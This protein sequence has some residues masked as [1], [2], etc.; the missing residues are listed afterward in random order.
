MFT[1]IFDWLMYFA[2]LMVIMVVVLFQMRGILAVMS[3]V[4]AAGWMIR[5][6]WGEDH[7]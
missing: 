1:K 6:A 7:V 3:I 2:S 4:L 5:F